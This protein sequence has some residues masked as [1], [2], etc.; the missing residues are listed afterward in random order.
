M[1][2][3][4]SFIIQGSWRVCGG[5]QHVVDAEGHTTSGDPVTQV[6]QLGCDANGLFCR[7]TDNLPWGCLDY[8]VKYECCWPMWIFEDPVFK[9]AMKNKNKFKLW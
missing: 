7:N 2:I 5:K 8:K 6:L 1:S 3:N 9:L 4:I